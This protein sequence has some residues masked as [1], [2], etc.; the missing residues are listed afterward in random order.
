M[1]RGEQSHINLS[2]AHVADATEAFLFEHLQKLWL[3]LQVHVSNLI[4]EDRAAMRDFE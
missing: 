3:N 4:E 1:R 2:I